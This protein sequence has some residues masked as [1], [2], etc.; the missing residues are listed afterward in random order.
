MFILLTMEGHNS[1]QSCVIT[2]QVRNISWPTEFNPDISQI[3]HNLARLLIPQETFFQ[4]GVVTHSPSIIPCESNILRNLCAD[5]LNFLVK[6]PPLLQKFTCK[7]VV[8]RDICAD[9]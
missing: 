7:I 5:L 1:A 3:M 6:N 2:D 9:S 4:S 8:P